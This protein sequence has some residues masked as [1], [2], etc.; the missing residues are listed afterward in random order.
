M[1]QE[2]RM[3][4]Y[5]LRLLIE[6]KERKKNIAVQYVIEKK[7]IYNKITGNLKTSIEKEIKQRFPF[8]QIGDVVS[9]RSNTTHVWKEDGTREYFYE[10]RGYHPLA[11]FYFPLFT[12]YIPFYIVTRFKESEL[13]DGKMIKNFKIGKSKYQIHFLSCNGEEVVDNIQNGA[14]CEIETLDGDKWNYL[15]V[16]FY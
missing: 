16:V 10:G 1:K 6:D 4:T 2:P 12:H 3:N 5:F 7:D 13:I 15:H 8:I 9:S 14:E 11:Y